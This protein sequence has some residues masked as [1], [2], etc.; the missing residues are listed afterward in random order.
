MNIV[1]YLKIKDKENAYKIFTNE[2][3]RSIIVRKNDQIKELAI[4]NKLLKEKIK[5]LESK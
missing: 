4:E 2:A 5:S 1:E 3:L